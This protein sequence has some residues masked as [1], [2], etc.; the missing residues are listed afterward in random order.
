[1]NNLITWML[2]GLIG[3]GL[4]MF[5]Y[6][7]L[8]W[9]VRRG[10]CAPKPF[11]WFSGSLVLRFGVVGI[12]FYL[13][14]DHHWQQLFPCLIGFILGRIAVFFVTGKWNAKWKDSHES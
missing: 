9:T 14:A 11:L 2:S 8:W 13:I 3:M 7:C 6:G 1:M 12:G 10:V 5:F 4:G